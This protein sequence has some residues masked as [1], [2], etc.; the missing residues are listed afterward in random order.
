MSAVA[1]VQSPVF[2]LPPHI[3]EVP[4]KTCPKCGFTWPVLTAADE[5]APVHACQ[6]SHG[7]TFREPCRKCERGFFRDRHG[8]LLKVGPDANGKMERL[9]AAYRHVRIATTEGEL[10]RP[11]DAE[12]LAYEAEAKRFAWVHYRFCGRPGDGLARFVWSEPPIFN[13]EERHHA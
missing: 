6:C 10:R 3:Q 8:A 4:L 1:E 2:A 11:T 5:E 7:L 13:V 12:M 9:R